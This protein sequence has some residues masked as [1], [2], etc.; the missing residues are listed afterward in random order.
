[1]ERLLGLSRGTARGTAR[2][3]VLALSVTTLGPLLHG[4]HDRDFAPVLV[5]HDE[6]QH[7]FQAASS[8]AQGL[9]TDHCIACHFVRSPRGAASWQLSGVHSFTAS[10]LLSQSDGPRIASLIAAPLPARA[11]PSRA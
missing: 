6:S 10:P 7:H 2:V 1:M 4:A 9:D 3:L 11:P 5:L 8:R